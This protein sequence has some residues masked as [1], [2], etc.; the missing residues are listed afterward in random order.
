MALTYY[1]Y[2]SWFAGLILLSGCTTDQNSVADAEY[3][4]V[5]GRVL[6]ED[7][8]SEDAIGEI[9][10]YAAK[11]D[12]QGEF[13]SV[14]EIESTKSGSQS[15]ELLVDERKAL[16]LAI[17]AENNGEVLSSFIQDGTE[18][19]STYHV[20]PIGL[21]STLATNL[22]REAVK[23]ERNEIIRKADITN[24]TR[25]VEP[26][27]VLDDPEKF[28][29][30]LDGLTEYSRARAIFAD[31]VSGN[32][33]MDLILTHILMGRSQLRLQMKLNLYDEKELI[34]EAL[35]DFYDDKLNAFLEGKKRLTDVT[36]LAHLQREML[37]KKVGASCD[38]LESEIDQ[39]TG[40]FAGLTLS[41]SILQRLEQSR[42]SESTKQDIFEISQK[43]KTDL[44]HPEGSAETEQILA[45][46]ASET[47]QRIRLDDIIDSDTF[48]ALEGEL[49]ASGGSK[50]TFD[51][52]ITSGS[53]LP[54]LNATHN[55]FRKEIDEIVNSMSGNLGGI[56][57]EVL[58][59]ILYLANIYR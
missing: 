23:S 28:G 55:Q 5:Q 47:V 19:G 58:S 31:P 29:A 57:P 14:S 27:P 18:N 20:E 22:F 30:L 44:F 25:W 11:I 17:L 15:F 36:S 1:K 59:E 33:D 39:S 10:I 46:Y 9:A 21:K 49:L 7:F 51:E 40:Y 24:I 2:I 48:D 12:S 4:T 34:D 52:H 43:F 37:S 54:D 16:Y 26:A 6:S 42:F 38:L 35:T 45:D 32:S 53:T 56:N 13:V 3:I 50:L 41:E 8:S